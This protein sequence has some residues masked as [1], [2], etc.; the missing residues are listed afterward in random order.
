MLLGLLGTAAPLSDAAEPQVGAPAAAPIS[1]LVTFSG[2]I[3]FES[4]AGLIRQAATFPVQRLVI[5]SPGGDVDAG[6]TLGQWIADHAVD[7]EVVGLCASACANYV[8][9]AA[10]RKIID[11]GGLV[12][13]HGSLLQKDFRDRAAGCSRRL[14]ELRVAEHDLVEFDTGALAVERSFCATWPALAERQADFYAHIG[15]DEAVTRLGQEP[16]DFH[17]AWTVPVEVMA[18]F[19]LTAI[20]AP[21]GYA[22]ADYLRRF[23]EADDPAPILSLGF[24]ASGMVVE[25]AR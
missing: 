9:A 7:V 3:T 13:W 25:L 17:A 8:F 18:R 19:G 6:L 21:P 12:V 15:V 14:A 1:A 20:E 5:D 4:V 16:Y 11:D 23:N 22:S 2:P 10:R 24:D